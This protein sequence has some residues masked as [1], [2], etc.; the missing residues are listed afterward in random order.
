MALLALLIRLLEFI[1][2]TKPTKTPATKS[3][4]FKV[5]KGLKETASSVC[6]KKCGNKK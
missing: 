4:K 3:I 6:I 1:E 5:G 2:V